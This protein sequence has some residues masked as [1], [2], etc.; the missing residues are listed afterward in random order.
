MRF[1]GQ[2]TVNSTKT[3][4]Y[5]LFIS[6]A[7][8]KIDSVHSNKLLSRMYYHGTKYCDA[9]PYANKNEYSFWV[10]PQNRSLG[11]N[12]WDTHLPVSLYCNNHMEGNYDDCGGGNPDPALKKYICL[13]HDTIQ[14]MKVAQNE[15]KS[16]NA[17]VFIEQEGGIGPYF[18]NKTALELEESITKAKA[19]I[20]ALKERLTKA[21]ATVITETAKRV[22]TTEKEEI[23][24]VSKD[25]L[26]IY[27]YN[28][29]LVLAIMII[30]YTIYNYYSSVKVYSNDIVLSSREIDL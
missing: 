14:D 20:V 1:E 16:H 26:N 8:H 29:M 25:I 13:G 22:Q 15:W 5:P 24:S 4:G 9:S 28:S 21:E 6:E 30:A 12:K 11:R 19:E 2:R 17:P 18:P 27:I 23:T 7:C 10:Y 3:V